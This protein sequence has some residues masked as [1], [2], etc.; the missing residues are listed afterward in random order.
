[1][2]RDQDGDLYLEDKDWL[3]LFDNSPIIMWQLYAAHRRVNSAIPDVVLAYF[4]KIAARL[5]ERLPENAEDVARLFD[6]KSDGKHLATGHTLTVL[7]HLRIYNEVL[8][9]K[10]ITRRTEKAF[11]LVADQYHDLGPFGVARIYRGVQKSLKKSFKKV[12]P[13]QPV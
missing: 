5:D 8:A 6:F 13:K 4:D 9:A 2:T 10:R 3:A 12:T 1:M 11:D 7:K